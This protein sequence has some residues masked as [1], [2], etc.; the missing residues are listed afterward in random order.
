M[1]LSAMDQLLGILC[2]GLIVM[3]QLCWICC[4]GIITDGDGST[5]EP[6]TRLDQP[7]RA[8]P[9]ILNMSFNV[10]ILNTKIIQITTFGGES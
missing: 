9:I 6:I 2:Y 8:N 1:E 5:L 10:G 4:G 3:D 7:S